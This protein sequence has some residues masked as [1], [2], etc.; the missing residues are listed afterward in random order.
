[1]KTA[2]DLVRG[3]ILQRFAE[4]FEPL[5]YSLGHHVLHCDSL[6]VADVSHQQGVIDQCGTCEHVAFTARV[7]CEHGE[8]VFQFGESGRL[9]WILADLA[10][11]AQTQEPK[12]SVD[13]APVGTR[14]SPERTI[15]TAADL[16]MPYPRPAGAA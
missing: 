13:P 3:L 15:T 14:T 9:D 5:H 8:I 2:D 1:M 6:E 12:R 7:W 16:S 11:L 4:R 10:E